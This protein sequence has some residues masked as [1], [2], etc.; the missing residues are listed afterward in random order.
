MPHGADDAER[1]EGGVLLADRAVGL[2]RLHDPHH[3]ADVLLRA[4]AQD[5]GEV[6]ALHLQ[7]REEVRVLGH[8][9]H[10]HLGAAVEVHQRGGV[11]VEGGDP[12]PAAG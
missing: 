7:Q 11:G 1:H 3:V 10:R 5:V 2:A 9:V 4:L 8:E 6:A 12:A